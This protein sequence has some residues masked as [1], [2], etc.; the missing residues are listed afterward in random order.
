MLLPPPK[1]K[2]TMKV[3]I[4]KCGVRRLPLLS[5]CCENEGLQQYVNRFPPA[6]LWAGKR[7]T[8][9]A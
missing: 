9:A 4:G 5:E 1:K 8:H 6:G 7:G 3:A 2:K